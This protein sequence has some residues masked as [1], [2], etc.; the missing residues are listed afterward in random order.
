MTKI[1]ESHDSVAVTA[2][3]H[4]DCSDA[5]VLKRDDTFLLVD[6]LGEISAP[7][8]SGLG[9]FH[10]GTRYLSHWE[11]RVCGTR[12][13]LLNSTIQEDNS[14]LHVQ[15]TTADI[16][17]LRGSLIPHG[18]LHLFRS[19]ILIEATLFEKLVITNYSHRT[20][21]IDI[22]YRYAADYVDIF[23]VRGAK[24]DHRG[25][26][27]APAFGPQQVSL[28][29]L[30]LD[31]RSRWT[32]IEF[33]RNDTIDDGACSI[34]L[35]LA[36]G[37]TI[38]V[39]AAV[40]CA[41]DRP[42]ALHTNHRQAVEQFVQGTHDRQS[43]RT[44]VVTSNE[45]FNQWIN[46]SLADLQ[47]L[48][49]NTDTG[50]FPYAGVPWFATPFGRDAIIAALETC[51]LQPQLSRDTLR[52]LAQTQ[53]TEFNAAAAA[54]PGKIIHEMRD[55]EMAELGEIPFR[56]YYGTVDATPLF[57]ILAGKY[58]RRSGDMDFIRSI[59]SNVLAALRWIDDYGDRDGDGFVEYQSHG[60]GGLVHQCWK[61]SNDSI[62]HADGSSPLGAI[63][64]CEVQ[65]YV[66]QAKLLCAEMA[67]M[68]GDAGLATQLIQQADKLKAQFN[69]SF[70]SPAINNFAIALD[71]NKRRCEVR[72]SNVGHLL[73]TDIIASQ[74]ILLSATHLPA[75]RH[76]MVGA[77]ARFLKAKHATIRC[78]ITMAQS[79]LTIRPSE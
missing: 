22:E 30:G 49:C 55:G 62:F 64:V 78:R 73:Y 58:L 41:E 25:E 45:R 42:T 75:T 15:L 35:T 18:T 14:F 56:R 1:I 72:S 33:S 67:T 40:R 44:S 12:P 57:L 26:L 20:A 48:I 4:S 71:G 19:L 5:Q 47:M 51:W 39:E 74:H 21:V 66:Y 8:T 10:K 77:F 38:S 68:L 50:E 65:G 17:D 13:K 69:E 2:S 52:F 54:E 6:R 60:D 70:W 11:M 61:D 24:R 9:L 59:W 34:P 31:H 16:K 27:L 37:E 23:E 46:R 29:Y 43:T 79:G 28:G 53:A 3:S 32:T 63:A 76:S 7:G 36:P